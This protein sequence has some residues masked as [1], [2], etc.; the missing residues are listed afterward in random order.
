MQITAWLFKHPPPSP[1]SPDALQPLKITGMK[2]YTHEVDQREVVLD[3]NIRF[4]DFSDFSDF[5]LLSVAVAAVCFVSA[6]L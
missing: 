2:A 1:P 6:D 3:L 4:S 5:S